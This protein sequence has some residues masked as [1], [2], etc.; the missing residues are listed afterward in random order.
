MSDTAL[1]APTRTRAHHLISNGQVPADCEPLTPNYG[2]FRGRT[3]NT[4]YVDPDLWPL[5]G[6][7]LNNF[8][9]CLLGSDGTFEVLPCA[10]EPDAGQ[11]NQ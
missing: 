1:L 2:Q 11:G 9:P 6:R 10:E 8:S 4:I 5:S 7:L 3:F